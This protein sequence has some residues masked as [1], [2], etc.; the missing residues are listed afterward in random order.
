MQIRIRHHDG[1]EE[2]VELDAQQTLRFGR[3]GSA[4]VKIS[5]PAVRSLH[6]GI[7]M[8]RGAFTVVAFKKVGK[9]RVNG[10]M[11]RKHILRVGDRIEVGD[12]L[13][14][15]IAA[16]EDE[17]PTGAA[18]TERHG[19]G[20]EQ[21][22]K[23]KVGKRHAKRSAASADSDVLDDLGCLDESPDLL[24][25]AADDWE[26]L[27]ENE[28]A[29]DV[30]AD[31]AFNTEV[32]GADPLAQDAIVEP[33]VER[34]EVQTLMWW[35][36]TWFKTC[37]LAVVVIPLIV[38]IA[39]Y[40][41]QLPDAR[42]RFQQADQFYQTGDYPNAI[43]SFSTYLEHHHD[44]PRADEAMV[45]RQLAMLLDELDRGVGAETLLER[46]QESMIAWGPAARCAYAQTGLAEL[47]PALIADLTRQGRVSLQKGADDTARTALRQAGTALAL[48]YR[49]LPPRL[50]SS[51]GAQQ[52]QLHY[53]RLEREFDQP[54]AH[55]TALRRIEEALKV[56]GIEVAYTVRGE[57][58]NAYPEL[59]TDGRLLAAMRAVGRAESTRVEVGSA[60]ENGAH[61]LASKAATT[62]P[63]WRQVLL[64]GSPSSST[65]N[66]TTVTAIALAQFGAVYGVDLNKR[67]ILWRQSV[68]SGAMVT[69][70]R[71][72][73]TGFVLVDRQRDELRAIAATSGATLWHR[74]LNNLAGPPAVSQQLLMVPATDG[75]MRAID[76]N[77]GTLIGT[78]RLPQ[79]LHVGP[80][81]DPSDPRYYQVAEHS[82]I[83]V[84][85][86]D[87]SKCL[88]SFYLGHEQGAVQWAP[89]V[90]D[91]YLLVFEQVGPAQSIAHVLRR[92]DQL[93]PIQSVVLSAIP[94]GKPVVM[95][96]M[97]Y[98]PGTD[99]LV[100]SLRYDSNDQRRPL[101]VATALA[102]HPSAV[103]PS[104]S[105]PD[106]S[107]RL[108]SVNGR[109]W[110]AGDGVAIYQAAARDAAAP[111]PRRQWDDLWVSQ[112]IATADGSAVVVG[113]E[114]NGGP[115]LVCR[116]GDAADKASSRIPLG[117]APAAPLLGNARSGE[118]W[119]LRLDG[120][121][122][123]GTISALADAATA[124]TGEQV[125][126]PSPVDDGLRSLS[127]PVAASWSGQVGVLG[128]LPGDAS[129]VLV[130]SGTEQVDCFPLTLPQRLAC[131]PV[132][133]GT[134]LVLAGYHGSM[135]LYDT[136]RRQFAA[137]EF[138][139]DMV[140]GA[141]PNWRTPAVLPDGTLV[142]SAGAAR[143][144]Q[145]QIS[146]D[147]A[148]VAAIASQRGAVAFASPLT[149]VGTTVWGVS[150]NRELCRVLVPELTVEK[151]VQLQGHA[152][153][154]PALVGRRAYLA[155]DQGELL[156][157]GETPG[158]EWETQLEIGPV[159]GICALDDQHVA[160]GSIDGRIAVIDSDSG[161]L[162]TALI[163]TGQRVA[164][165]PV[166]V[167]KRLVLLTPDG[168]LLVM[169][170]NADTLLG[171]RVEGHL[172]R[173]ESDE[174]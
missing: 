34:P 84:L 111:L 51:C 148:A 103:H 159:A 130:A 28:L 46:L 58:L 72:G 109:L 59:T 55:R 36:A 140:N 5:G 153:W 164:Y 57:L 41:Q 85:A 80:T 83:Y 113:R 129:L 87:Q 160:V 44:D 155:T 162:A 107:P 1:R 70:I 142:V 67:R 108:A 69:P 112:I 12:N 146:T 97:V 106:I 92:G 30:F 167:G 47:L 64:P 7:L 143:L 133:V 91:D 90:L 77:S 52:L 171:T 53:T 137:G 71:V 104:A 127:R 81:I 152:Q 60:A 25:D 105:R 9:I 138:L 19:A 119:V 99:G 135:M 40:V 10:S 33:T 56:G 118:F 86:I 35:N 156:C 101:H 79:E 88:S 154:G 76:M 136:R 82:L 23:R 117:V 37:L 13:I 114:K 144:F 89:V 18:S 68:S 132:A 169:R 16:R 43:A 100:H 3:R 172:A 45:K 15:V 24:R 17:E 151:D 126:I 149:A 145:L 161:R 123:H 128:C 120:M 95:G 96:D 8:R 141:L 32:P 125:C 174:E 94:S 38:L 115:C 65:E 150:S 29:G 102:P 6:F 4:D 31:G 147:G 62:E 48:A 170:S 168:C 21:A 122:C 98:W 78:V 66:A 75:V 26:S 73:R 139:P 49:Y 42:R 131:P 20:K 54:N 121:L 27:D 134:H 50:Q 166:L 157:L 74:P 63:A 124:V 163:N 165:G 11:V 22:V 61:A 2:R 158:G 116:E 173:G 110:V 14:E 93:E 39:L